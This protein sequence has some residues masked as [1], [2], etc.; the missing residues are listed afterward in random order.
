MYRR[1]TKAQRQRMTHCNQE[2]E[3]AQM[4]LS[5]GTDEGTVGPMHSGILLSRTEK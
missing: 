3:S 4:S 5:R 1:K 2:V